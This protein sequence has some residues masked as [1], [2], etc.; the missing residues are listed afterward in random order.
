[1]SRSEFAAKIKTLAAVAKMSAETKA[2]LVKIEKAFE[3]EMERAGVLVSFE[4]SIALFQK[5]I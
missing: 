4:E 1:M 2:D 5:A 3:T